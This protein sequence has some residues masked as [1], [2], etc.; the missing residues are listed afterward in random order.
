LKT[1]NKPYIQRVLNFFLR[2]PP[3]TNGK[4]PSQRTIYNQHAAQLFNCPFKQDEAKT[5][6]KRPLLLAGCEAKIRSSVS[7]H[8]FPALLLIRPPSLVVCRRRYA[9]GPKPD[10]PEGCDSPP[11]RLQNQAP[12]PKAPRPPTTRFGTKKAAFI[13]KARKTALSFCEP[14]TLSCKLGDTHER[15]HAHRT[16]IPV[17]AHP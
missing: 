5:K 7:T 13:E 8:L 9:V 12:A 10:P 3:F 4:V 1:I 17:R 2:K 15:Q 14:T 16:S 6:K 11:P